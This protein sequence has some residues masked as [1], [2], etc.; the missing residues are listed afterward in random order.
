MPLLLGYGNDELAN[1]VDH[2]EAALENAGVDVGLCETE[3]T[4]FKANMFSR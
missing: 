3:W 1:H 4:K 2:F